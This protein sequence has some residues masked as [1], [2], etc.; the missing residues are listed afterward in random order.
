MTTLPSNGVRSGSLRKTLLVALLVAGCGTTVTQFARHE[1]AAE[2]A[3]GAGRYDEA[4]SEWAQAARSAARSGQR[5]EAR[6][7]RA[8]SL[9]RAGRFEQARAALEELLRDS[10]KGPRSARAAYDRAVLSIEH[11]SNGRGY[12]EL[13][14][15]LR[16]YPDA[17][18]A[19]A[20]LERY[21]DWLLPRGEEAVRAYL[22]SLASVEGTELGEKVLYETARSLERSSDPRAA[23]DAFERVAARYPYPT[24][25]L[26]DDALWNAAD[27][28]VKLD[29]PEKAIA[30]L[31][32]LLSRRETAYVQGSYERS[33][34][35]EAEFRIAELYRDRLADVPRA[36]AAFE[37]LWE[38]HPNSRLRDDAK[39]NAATLAIA[40]GDEVGACRDLAQLV[41]GDPTSRYVACATK[42]CPSLEL[43]GGAGACH[44]YVVRGRAARAG[45]P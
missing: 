14:A 12:V 27:L 10:P 31:S 3:Y 45:E 25:V 15:M 7:R 1:A 35:A 16:T 24:G 37:R 4:A 40:L 11:G 8:A 9:S 43:P 36:R 32:Q 17:G 44:D 23:R 2:R 18:V 41:A 42:L 28:D 34:Y 26:W 30:L 39:W 22:G 38:A 20:A 29:E 21:L 13:D 5:D 6:Y 33:R 19:G